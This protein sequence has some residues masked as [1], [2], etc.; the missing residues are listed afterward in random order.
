MY[1]PRCAILFSTLCSLTISGCGTYTPDV[2]EFWGTPTD[3]DAKLGLIVEQVKCELT[4]AARL[5]EAE[6]IGFSSV[7]GRQ[8]KFVEEKWAADVLFQ[9]TIDEKGGFN[10][11][12]TLT[13]PLN[14]LETQSFGFGAQLSSEGYRQDKLHNLYKFRDLIGPEKALPSKAQIA[15]ETCVKHP[16]SDA[17][18]I[19]QSDLK[20][21][22]WLQAVVNT[23]VR[24]E[25]NLNVKNSFVK[26][27]VVVHDVKFEVVSAGSFTP[28][29]KLVRVSVNPGSSPFLSASRDRAQEVIITIGPLASDGSL[30]AAGR[31]ASLSSQIKAGIDS[32]SR[33]IQQ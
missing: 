13:P 29:W 27:G 28:S 11:G 2:Q 25:T 21:Y 18:L 16:N 23:Q 14:K 17:T 10:P 26:D 22:E 5:I 33:F 7:Q 20:L 1:I 30:K 15:A 32:T 8:L 4:R 9:F 6:D 24:Q 3:M 19:V 12:V 31:D